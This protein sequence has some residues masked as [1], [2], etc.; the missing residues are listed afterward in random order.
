MNV[1]PF[2]VI[3]GEGHL[4]L[5]PARDNWF[6]T[7]YAPAN[8]INQTATETLADLNLGDRVVST[9]NVRMNRRARWKWRLGK[10]SYSSAR[11][12]YYRWYT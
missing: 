11:V 1:N 9:Q 12:R 3:T 5:S 4:K 10:T 6:E 7:R 8:V 2:A